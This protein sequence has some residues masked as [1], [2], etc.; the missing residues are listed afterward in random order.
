MPN[1]SGGRRR[2]SAAARSQPASSRLWPGDDERACP[3][4]RRPLQCRGAPA[5]RDAHHCTGPGVTIRIVLADDHPVVAEG[6][7]SL[8]NAQGDMKVVALTGNGLDA[9]R[10]CL[11]T[12]P[13]IAVMD[14][15]M[16]E[17]N[18]T[19]AAEMLRRRRSSTRVVR[20]EERRVGKE[21]RSR[22]SPYH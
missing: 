1:V 8:I 14:Q 3:S 17:M 2:W 11:E 6:L 9:V 21:C 7:R 22:W 12:K 10:S 13:D 16:P 18:G 5:R 15:A 4:R 19:E 20:S